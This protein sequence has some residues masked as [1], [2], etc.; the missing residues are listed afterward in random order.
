M[1]LECTRRKS[2]YGLCG[3]AAYRGGSTG[4]QRGVELA[5]PT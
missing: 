4:K 2:L 1:N 3:L 5:Q